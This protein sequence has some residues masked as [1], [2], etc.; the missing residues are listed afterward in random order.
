MLKY[1]A[2]LGNVCS[3]QVVSLYQLMQ[4][5]E[6]ISLG[7]FVYPVLIKSSGSAGIAFHAHV[8]K[9]GLGSD[10]YVRNA[11]LSVYLKYGP[12]EHA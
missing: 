5:C 1:C 7:T 2:P 8:V 11:T 9:L 4:R 12:V 6:D 3:N 10:H